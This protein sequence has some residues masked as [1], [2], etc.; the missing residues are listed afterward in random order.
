M[1]SVTIIGRCARAPGR[2]GHGTDRA[3]RRAGPTGTSPNCSRAWAWNCPAATGS[4]PPSPSPPPSRAPGRVPPRM[5]KC[6][7]EKCRP[8]PGYLINAEPAS[9]NCGTWVKHRAHRLVADRLDDL[10]FRQ[11]PCQQPQRPARVP[12]GR[13]PA[14]QR[15]E[16][17][18]APAVGL[19]LI[20]PL[21]GVPP[22][23][24]IVT[25]EE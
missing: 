17:R 18:F 9:M 11:P 25:L 8:P 1:K 16:L 2:H 14:A 13:R 19:G 6:R 3:H 15:E 5:R 23:R 22:I 20:L 7:A 24:C 10:Q 4:S 12:L 21:R